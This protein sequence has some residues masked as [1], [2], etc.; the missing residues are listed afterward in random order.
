MKKEKSVK[1]AKASGKDYE[2]ETVAENENSIRILAE[3]GA[4]RLSRVLYGKLDREMAERFKYLIIDGISEEQIAEAEYAALI[5]E[6]DGPEKKEELRRFR[7]TAH[8]LSNVALALVELIMLRLTEPAAGELLEYLSPGNGNG[9]TLLTAARAAGYLGTADEAMLPM[10]DAQEAASFLLKSE[11]DDKKEFYQKIWHAD[12]W[13]L[14]FLAGGDGGDE[15]Y[16]EFTERFDGS[17]EP[18][19][20]YGMEDKVENLSMQLGRLMQNEDSKPFTVLVEGEKESGR[21]TAVKA[22]AEKNSL[23][24]YTVDFTFLLITKDPRT[25]MARIVRACALEGR[26]LCVRNISR[27]ADTIFLVQR[28]YKIYRKHSVMPFIL[29]ADIKVKLAPT[30][31]EYYISM[32]IPD[33]RAAGLKL[34]Q[35]FLP[36]EYKHMAP[37]LSSKMKLTA[38]QMERVGRAIR[39]SLQSGL[40][41]DERGICRICYEILDDGRYENVKWVEPGFVL[42]DLK[43]DKHNRAILEDICLQVEHR[44]MVYD[45]WD[46]RRHYA[47]GRCV[48][49]ILAGP[50][51]TGKT[52]T[53]HALA[54]RLGLELYKVDLSQIVDKYV[55]E[56]EKRLEEVFARAERSNMVLFFDEADAV[57]GKRSNVK[58]AQDKY[59]N[60]EISFILQRIEEFDGIVILATNNIQNIDNAFMRRI[61]YVLTFE[62]P[63]KTT[64]ED[65]WREA[66]G[67]KIPLSDDIDFDYLAGQF[68]LSGGEI[69][70]IVL[71]AVFYGA[72]D[73]G[74]VTMEH[75]MKAVYRELTKG[76]RVTMDGDYGK[77][78]YMLHD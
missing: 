44:Q 22:A 56:T 17:T 68:D 28:L 37:S 3:L 38:G 73:G 36:E 49:V 1:K 26:T 20:V 54:S 33:S 46:L 60:T 39:T 7:L 4:L 47:Y 63:D 50:P 40:S 13:L 64:R 2:T 29:L 55:G 6:A 78:G 66:F 8:C 35:A 19:A 25:V 45:D 74:M 43:I 57:M 21:Y 52:M 67:E 65:I 75:I 59:A 51:G 11:K 23:P 16:E 41:L 58:D 42:D 30:L 5:C 71:N 14:N 53:V 61:R 24:L 31:T 18:V 48:S 15:A 72:S 12:T 32:K 62:R 70:N 9:V 76:R 27:T 10:R 69:K 34:W 77:F